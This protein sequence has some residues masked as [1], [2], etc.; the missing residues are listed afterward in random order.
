MGALHL[1]IKRWW[2]DGKDGDESAVGLKGSEVFQQPRESVL[3]LVV[4]GE[5]ASLLRDGRKELRVQ[6][7]S[8]KLLT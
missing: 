7:L 5:A 4:P 1:G 8:R 6:S 3:R 2:A